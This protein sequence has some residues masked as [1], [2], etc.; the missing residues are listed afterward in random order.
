LRGFL[1]AAIA[2]VMAIGS[3]AAEAP[4]PRITYS[5]TGGVPVLTNGRITATWTGGYQP[6]LEL[7]DGDAPFTLLLAEV[8]EFQDH[9]GNGHYE[10]GEAVLSAATAPGAGWAKRSSGYL[11]AHA[12]SMEVAGT[13]GSRAVPD[14]APGGASEV[15]LEVALADEPVLLKGAELETNEVMLTTGVDSW[16]WASPTDVI[17]LRFLIAGASARVGE[18]VVDT[19]SPSVS[20]P[21]YENRVEI[22]RR[23]A[24]LGYVRWPAWATVGTVLGAVRSLAAPSVRGTPATPELPSGVELTFVFPSSYGAQWVE[25]SP[26]VGVNLAEADVPAEGPLPALAAGLA[27]VSALAVA[28]FRRRHGEEPEKRESGGP[29]R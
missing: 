17:A 29:V 5:E 3:V 28:M 16:P 23:D 26:V 11:T 25:F 7:R 6:L 22:F 10:P 9:N 13:A 2:A 24:D 8:L 19:D 20:V 1:A 27:V 21:P 15:R 18:R 4:P 12:Y 14:G